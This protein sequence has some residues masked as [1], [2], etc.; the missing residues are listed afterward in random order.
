MWNPRKT[1]RFTSEAIFKD[2]ARWCRAVSLAPFHKIP[3]GRSGR[4]ELAEWL[5][6][7]GNPLTA[8]VQVNRIWHH[9]FGRGLVRSVDYFGIRGE[10]PSHPELLD[11]LAAQ[12]IETDHWSLKRTIRRMVISHTYQMASDHRP[13]AEVVDPDNRLLGR[14]PRRRLNAEC[15]RDAMLAASGQLDPGRG[16]SSLGLE[17]SGN[18]SGLGGQVNPPTWAGK[19]PDYIRNRRSVY[20]P[21]KRE[22]PMGE[23]EILSVF[24]FP[25]PSEF[26][27][28]R[29]ETTVA[30]QAL[31]LLNSPF[32]KE[33]AR[34][35]AERVLGDQK[36]ADDR[37]R[38]ARLYLL[39]VG[40]S[41]GDEQVGEALAFLDQC[42]Q[43][44]AGESPNKPAA[45][46]RH[47][48]W[49]QLCH[50]ML[51]SNAFLFRE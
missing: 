23:L 38:I 31:F 1:A 46:L 19:I 47:G 26:T 14:M 44:L 33:Q 39:S 4:K 16:G 3:P 24:D 22:R 21:L 29:A 37:D 10:K 49:I 20:L 45:E 27:G 35:L 5:T 28:A 9:I 7:P 12:L 32:V 17:M 51:T 40:R 30:T 36:L 43:D 50:A 11:F 13:D 18:I 15:I 8:R 41:P 48:A 6:D 42:Q 34:G 2:W 25:H